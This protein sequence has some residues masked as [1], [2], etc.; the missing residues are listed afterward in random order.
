MN[1]EG[2]RRKESHQPILVMLFGRMSVKGDERG[3]SSVKCEGEGR[4]RVC[5]FVDSV[6]GL[7]EN[8]WRSVRR[9]K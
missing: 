6:S 1:E 4:T 7:H 2:G 8:L 5:Q 3:V 9:W